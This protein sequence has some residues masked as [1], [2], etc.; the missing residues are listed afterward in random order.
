MC[1][2]EV[3][4]VSPWYDLHGWLGL[5][6]QLLTYSQLLVCCRVFMVVQNAAILMQ[7]PTP[8]ATTKCP[9]TPIKIFCVTKY[10]VLTR[11][12]EVLQVI[13]AIMML[14]TIINIS[15]NSICVH[16]RCT[17]PKTE[18]THLPSKINSSGEA[19]RHLSASSVVENSMNPMLQNKDFIF[20]YDLHLG[21][22]EMFIWY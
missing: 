2:K 7:K 14:S 11:A 6:R 10:S 8:T 16:K 17:W 20:F 18:T 5:K 12:K 1:C 3:F 21:I 4:C 9:Q 13:E 15:S 19:M 22:S